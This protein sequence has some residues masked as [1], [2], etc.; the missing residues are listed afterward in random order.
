MLHQ[1]RGS[2]VLQNGRG[3]DIVVH[4]IPVKLFQAVM[5]QSKR[6]A[7]NNICFEIVN[8]FNQISQKQYIAVPYTW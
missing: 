1:S 4:I 3:I 6:Y 7:A 5:L 2:S 8:S